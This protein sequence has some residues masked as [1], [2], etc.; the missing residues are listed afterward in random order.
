[1]VNVCD[2]VIVFS[3][4]HSRDATLIATNVTIP[5]GIGYYIALFWLG[6]LT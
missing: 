5:L 3:T 1:M 6:A 4:S 2:Y